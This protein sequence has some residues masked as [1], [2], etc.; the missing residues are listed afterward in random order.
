M[1]AEVCRR[2]MEGVRR[3]KPGVFLKVTSGAGEPGFPSEGEYRAG[4]DPPR[5][6]SFR[7]RGAGMSR[8]PMLVL[9]CLVLGC[10][11]KVTVPPGTGGTAE[12]VPDPYGDPPGYGVDPFTGFGDV[13]SLAVPGGVAGQVEAAVPREEGPYSVQ[14][15][16]CSTPGAA[17]S[18]ASNLESAVGQRVFVDREGGYHKVRVGAFESGE[19]A[20]DLLQTLKSMGYT[21]AWVVRRSPGSAR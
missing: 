11:S 18:L 10:G 12:A 20:G 9:L 19:Q 8:I 21:D 1:A 4:Y 17:A 6:A 13:V 5:R 14:V 7:L 3:E 2:G 16:A 15:A